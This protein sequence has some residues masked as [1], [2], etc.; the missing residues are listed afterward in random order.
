MAELLDVLH[1]MVQETVAA[2]KPADVAFGTVT[3]ASPLSIRV[4]GTMQDIPAV[5]LVLTWP[6][7]E[8]RIGSTTINQALQAG[9]RVVMLR[10]SK[11]QRFIVL[12]RVQGGG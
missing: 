5:A 2:Q 8:I 9:D 10:V 4:E 11:G 3:S 7:T 6:V 1:Q 12:S